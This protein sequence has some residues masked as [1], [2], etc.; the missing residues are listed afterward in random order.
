[1]KESYLHSS[2][3]L[4]FL[5]CFESQFLW[6]WGLHSIWWPMSC[7]LLSD[8]TSLMLVCY[9]DFGHN[10]FKFLFSELS[11]PIWMFQNRALNLFSLTSLPSPGIWHPTYIPRKIILET[12]YSG[13]F[14]GTLRTHMFLPLFASQILEF[15]YIDLVHF[16]SY[17]PCYCF[18]LL[19]W[20]G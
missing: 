5:S 16:L 4:I 9:G 6:A 12:Y 14:L 7:Q 1:M 3:T 2:D 15:V 13:C 18:S 8:L 17:T 11:P 19:T 20:G 10:A